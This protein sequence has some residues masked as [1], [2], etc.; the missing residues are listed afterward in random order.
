MRTITKCVLGLVVVLVIAAFVHP[1]VARER[2]KA[3]YQLCYSNLEH[4]AI[5]ML[6]YLQD[7]HGRLPDAAHWQDQL[8]PY[9]KDRQVYVCPNAEPGAGGGYAMAPS[10][11]GAKV[12][13]YPDPSLVIVF[14]DAD[15]AGSPITRH[16]GRM[17]C[18]FLDGHVYSMP[19]G[20]EY[21]GAPRDMPPRARK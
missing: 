14:F 10:L 18:A 13:D 12:S 3:R 16:Q 6:L 9:I 8:F 17:Q 4:I 19:R 7:N 2:E 20:M 21:I 1:V 15:A 5:G 11:G